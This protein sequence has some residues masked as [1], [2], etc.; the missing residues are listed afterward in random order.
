MTSAGS[1]LTIEGSWLKSPGSGSNCAITPPA[2][3]ED[4]YRRQIQGWLPKRCPSAR[5]TS[6]HGDW[7]PKALPSEDEIERDLDPGQYSDLDRREV[8]PPV[9]VGTAA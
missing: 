5:T 6:S 1:G 7:L 9:Q 4:L 3:G 8:D 2:L